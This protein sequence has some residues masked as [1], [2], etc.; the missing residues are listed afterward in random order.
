MVNL[1]VELYDYP[2]ITNFYYIQNNEVK[3]FGDEIVKK[4]REIS[5]EPLIYSFFMDER[6][7]AKGKKRKG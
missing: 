1:L 7:C 5:I 6:D 2:C 3:E 4:L